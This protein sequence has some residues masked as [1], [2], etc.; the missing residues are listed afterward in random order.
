MSSTEQPLDKSLTGFAKPW[1]IGPWASAFANLCTNLYPMFPAC[2]SG[3]TKT[4]ALPATLES[5]AFLAPTYSTIAA[6]A[7][8][9]P[10]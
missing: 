10:S 1:T 8:N 2:K 9:S 5:G 4:F 7:C 6:S 3:N